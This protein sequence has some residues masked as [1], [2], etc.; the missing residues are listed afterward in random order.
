M[1]RRQRGDAGGA[2]GVG[3]G[4]GARAVVLGVAQ[5]VVGAEVEGG[6]GARAVVEHN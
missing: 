3:G 5:V 6:G 4:V 1:A 2:Y